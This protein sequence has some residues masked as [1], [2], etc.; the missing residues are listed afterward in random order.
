MWSSLE[1]LEDEGTVVRMPRGR[2]A[3]AERS[4]LLTGRIKVERSGRALVILD[5]PDAPLI[6]ERGALRPA[7]DGDRVLVEPVRY[8]RGGLHHAKIRRVLERAR[9][10]IVAVASPIARTRLLAL[11]DRIGPYVIVLADDSDPAPPGMAVAATIVEYPS[12][13]RDL[14]VRVERV[15]GEIGRLATEIRSV[16]VLRG[17]DEDFPEQAEAEANAFGE[18][19]A[20]DLHGREDLR[21]ELTVTV[22]PVDAKDHDDAVSIVRMATGWRLV[23][24]IADVSHYVVPGTALDGAAYDRSTSVYFPGRSVP[25]LPEKLSGGLASLHPGVDR[26]AVSVFLEI[27][28]SGDVRNTSFARSAIHSFASLTYEQVQ[29][30]LDDEGF[31]PASTDEKTE[32]AAD[33]AP[34]VLEEA[35]ADTDAEAPAGGTLQEP[36]RASSR[37]AAEDPARIAANVRTSLVEM[38]RCADAL[39]RRR[40]QR[41]AIDM[42]LPEAVVVLDE[43]G[44]VSA[45]RRRPRRFAHRLVEEFMLAANEAVAGKID[46]SDVPFLYR[47]HE[48]PDDDALVQL[49]TRARALGLRLRHDGGVVA[50]AVFQKLLADAAGRPEARQINNMV[51]RTMT[52][53]R[54][55][56]EKEIHFGLASRCYTHFTSPIRRYPD[57]IAHRAL[58]ATLGQNGQARSRE[59]L[60]PE[61]AHTSERERRAMDAERDVVAAAGCLFMTSYVGKR[62]AGTVSGVDRFGFWVELDV[63]FVEGFVHVGKLREYFDWV[64]EKMELQSRVSAAVIHIGQSMRVRVVSVDLASRRIE[65]EPA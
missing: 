11:D 35:E 6:V 58:L 21:E 39:H 17:I 34:A 20:E 54:Y 55:S 15:L 5:V 63:A 22:D 49:A 2:W 31:A 13:H 44:D 65:L 40:M 50:P 19:S 59:A 48:R 23:V 43:A 10:T 45:I 32:S 28:S 36:S 60:R 1:S 8:A 64:P 53:A 46:A 57:I 52:R 33:A 27:D 29:A 18:P 37:N 14:T 62:L 61:A 24:S 51:L 16:C 3:L 47:I 9:R 38:A 12:S 25:M 41:G 56:A 7:M 4:G 42:D 30:V 26:L